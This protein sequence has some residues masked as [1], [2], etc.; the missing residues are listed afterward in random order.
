VNSYKTISSAS[1]AE[2]IIKKSKFVA[3]CTPVSTKQEV[4]NFLTNLK[5]EYEGATHL[6]Y[7]YV[8]EAGEEKASD[9]G[10]PSGT[11]G[12]PILNIIKRK[13]LTNILVVVIRYFGGVKLGAGGLIRAYSKTANE[14]LTNAQIVE[15][16]EYLECEIKLDYEEFN[17]L[18][19][20]KE[21]D[22]F[23]VIK[24]QYLERVLVNLAVLEENIDKLQNALNNLFNKKIKLN[25]VKTI[26]KE[27][28]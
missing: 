20:L 15:F 4:D 28:K 25:Y 21:K 27:K 9:D 19:K 23:E 12:M 13:A 3:I 2:L 10:E 7:A 11:A 14:C 5:K 24:K 17:V 22:L 1:Y 16:V 6:C 18:D 26:Y 8:L